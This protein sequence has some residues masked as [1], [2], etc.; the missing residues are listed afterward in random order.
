MQNHPSVWLVYVRKACARL[1]IAIVLLSLAWS[2]AM[3]QGDGTPLLDPMR[4]LMELGR[5]Y[6]ILQ[7]YTTAP[8]E[9][10]IQ[11]RAGATPATAWRPPHLKKDLWSEPTAREVRGEPGARLYHRVR[12]SGLKPGTRYYYRVYDP[13]YCPTS[14]ERRWGAEPPWRR[15]YAFTTLAPQGYKT[16]IHLPVKVLIM[17]NVVNVQSAYADPNQPAPPPSPL[18][19]QEIARIHE[20]YAVAARFFWVNSGMRLWVDFHLFID[21]RWQRWGPEPPNAEGFYKGLPL[22]RAYAGV[23][24]APPGGGTFTILDTQDPMRPNLQP[25]YEEK[26]YA[27]QIEQAFP[28]RW[29]PQAK[30]WEFYNSGGGTLGVDN[31]P[32]GVPARSQ[33]LGGGDTAWLVAHEFHHQLESFGAFSLANREDERIVF[34]HPEPRYRRLTPDGTTQQNAWSTAGRHGEHWNVMA[35]WLRTLSDLQWLRFYF[36]EPIIVRDADQDGVPD[37]DP[38][39]PLDEKRFGSDP[40][41]PRTDGHLND[42]HKV[43]L[44]TWAPAPLQNTFVKPAFQSRLPNPKAPDSDGDGIPDGVDPYPLYP[45]IPLIPYQRIQLDGNPHEWEDIPP[46][47]VL[48]QDGRKLVFKQ[49]HDGDSYYALFSVQGEWARLHVGYDGEGKGIFSGEGTFW[50]DI[51]NGTP[52]RFW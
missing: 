13:A 52:L 9:T 48:E 33:F 32:E 14:E 42:L 39:L 30:R 24:F 5:D 27:G 21:E 29:N 40:R 36:G 11:L 47:G 7:Y 22:N 50:L 25:V 46:A 19:P 10:R 17:P 51:R 31:F 15:E 35:Y 3:P 41:R 8:C 37:D 49:A 38:R 2:W 4:P 1:P 28:R 43:M 34:N 45:W 18:T 23:D 20:E 44:S 26:P 16:I 6:A 12:L